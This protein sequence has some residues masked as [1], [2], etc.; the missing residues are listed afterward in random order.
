MTRP[1]GV[2]CSRCSLACA[3]GLA[4]PSPVSQPR[5]FFERYKLCSGDKLDAAGGAEAPGWQA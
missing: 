2:V 1:G 4:I 3:D 5:D